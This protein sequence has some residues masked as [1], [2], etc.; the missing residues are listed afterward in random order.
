MSIGRSTRLQPGLR[1]RLQ[2]VEKLL[3][4]R[5]DSELCRDGVEL[6]GGIAIE[7]G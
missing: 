1:V 6:P 7:P 3:K 5:K 4:V 2:I